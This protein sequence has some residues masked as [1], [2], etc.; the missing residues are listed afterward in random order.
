MAFITI[1]S[2]RHKTSQFLPDLAF[3]GHGF[4]WLCGY[5]SDVYALLEESTQESWVQIFLR[6][7]THWLGD[8]HSVPLLCDWLLRCHPD[9]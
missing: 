1:S 6:A 4:L 5:C 7:F 2:Q 8:R 9:S 3:K